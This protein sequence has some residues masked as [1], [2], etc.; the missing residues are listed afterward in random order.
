[1]YNTLILPL[2]SNYARFSAFP[3]PIGN[4]RYEEH[5]HRHPL[6]INF[7]VCQ[8]LCLGLERATSHVRSTIRSA[9]PASLVNTSDEQATFGPLLQCWQGQAH[10]KGVCDV[11]LLLL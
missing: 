9:W 6:A 4:P 2:E 10:A 5:P 1:M 7:S 11:L 8:E 3:R